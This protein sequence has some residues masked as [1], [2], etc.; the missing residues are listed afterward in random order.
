MSASVEMAGF[1]TM[2]DQYATKML[3]FP[4][5]QGFTLEGA[6]MLL[7][8]GKIKTYVPGEVLFQEREPALFTQLVLEGKLQVF[9]EREGRELV[10]TELWPGTI[11][12]EL[13]VLCNIPRA[14]AAR[15]L[16]TSATLL[17]SA[18]EFRRM[19]VRNTPLSD[20]ILAQSLRTLIEKEHSLI[21]TLTRAQ[22][23]PQ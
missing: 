18:A 4:L 17:W 9:V 10:L 1:P 21:D 15:A 13:G 2:L 8:S 12:G 7:E 19:L 16:E 3:G 5:L 23:A 22:A 14:A 6:K 20:R 11:L